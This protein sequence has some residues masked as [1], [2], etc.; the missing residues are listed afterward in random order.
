MLLHELSFSSMQVRNDS[1]AFGL[2]CLPYALTHQNDASKPTSMITPSFPH[3]ATLCECATKCEL[4][5]RSRDIYMMELAL[6]RQFEGCVLSKPLLRA[7][8]VAAFQAPLH[9]TRLWLR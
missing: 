2:A 4:K 1:P 9:T 3:Q 6:Q 7:A 8:A 5:T